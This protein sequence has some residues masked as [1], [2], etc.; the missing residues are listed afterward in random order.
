M[1]RASRNPNKRRIPISSCVTSQVAEDLEDA[2]CHHDISMS[3]I[4]SRVLA[5]ACNTRFPTD[6]AEFNKL[7]PLHYS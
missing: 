1:P 2:A 7:Y 6:V 5:K 3:E 4:V